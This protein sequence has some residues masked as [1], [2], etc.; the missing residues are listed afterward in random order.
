MNLPAAS[1]TTDDPT[2][3]VIAPCA[4]VCQFCPTRIAFLR[5]LHELTPMINQAPYTAVRFLPTRSAID[6]VMMEEKNPPR[7][8]A[9]VTTPNPQVVICTQVGAPARP[10]RGRFDELQMMES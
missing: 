9:A 1:I 3:I 2:V 7:V 6:P 5:E 10:G 8:K 4:Q